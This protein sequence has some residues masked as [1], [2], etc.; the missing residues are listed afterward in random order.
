MIRM[1]NGPT[2]IMGNLHGWFEWR[3]AKKKPLRGAAFA[4]V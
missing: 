4:V 1:E 3:A 2:L